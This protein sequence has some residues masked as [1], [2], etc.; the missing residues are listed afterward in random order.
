[1]DEILISITRQASEI[2]N[3]LSLPESDVYTIIGRE[4]LNY[5]AGDAAIVITPDLN[6]Y[7]SFRSR[8]TEILRSYVRD[9]GL[10]K[11][12][13]IIRISLVSDTIDVSIKTQALTDVRSLVKT[14]LN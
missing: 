5:I 10:M 7:E 9:E 11:S 12:L 8:N 4:F 14:I 1:M 13:G 2:I 3:L 6:R